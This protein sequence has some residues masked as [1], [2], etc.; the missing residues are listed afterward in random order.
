MVE[1]LE[2]TGSSATS[3]YNRMGRTARLLYTV[4]WIL[5]SLLSTSNKDIKTLTP[6][7]PISIR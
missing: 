2:L 7:I 4:F 3:R 1:L 6:T 5:G